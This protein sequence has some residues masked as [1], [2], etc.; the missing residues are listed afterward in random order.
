MSNSIDCNRR[1]E[2]M[3]GSQT[4]CERKRKIKA[5]GPRKVKKGDRKKDR[6]NDGKKSERDGKETQ[7]DKERKWR[8]RG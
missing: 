2:Q 7:R 5:K 8:E 3:K 4:G 6:K 1:E